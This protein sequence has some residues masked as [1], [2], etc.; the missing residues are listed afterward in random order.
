MLLEIAFILLNRKLHNIRVILLLL[1]IYW[2]YIFIYFNYSEHTSLNRLSIY[3]I[4]ANAYKI[5]CYTIFEGHIRRSLLAEIIVGLH[6]NV[7]F[8]YKVVVVMSIVQKLGQGVRIDFSKLWD[9]ER[10]TYSTHVV[11]TPEFSAMG[12]VVG[13]YY[14][15][16][17]YKKWSSIFPQRRK[18]VDAS[19]LD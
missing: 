16:K 15:W 3:L 18:Y 5:F 2:E 4:F 7:A 11:E 19:A 1:N 12:L 6:F 13:L 9:T 14:E 10:D 8:R 17:C